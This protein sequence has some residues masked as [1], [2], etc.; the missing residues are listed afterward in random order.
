MSDIV[1]TAA[2]TSSVKGDIN[3]NVRIHAGYVREAVR[4]K[5]DFI[6]FPELSLTGYEPEL[7]SELAMSIDDPRLSP[8]RELAAKH[9][10]T[11]AAG[12]PIFRAREK[13]GIG[14]IVISPN[15]TSV[16]LKQHVTPDEKRHFSA[17]LVPCTVKVRGVSIGLAICADTSHASHAEIAAKL[18]ASVYA[19]GVLFDDAES[20][21]APRFQQYAARHHMAI[22]MANY[23]G[24][25]GGFVGVGKSGVWD[26]Q[27]RLIAAAPDGNALV[28]A[29]R[30]SGTW[31]GTA[32]PM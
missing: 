17:G 29:E 11:I 26:E 28:I 10:I 19:A 20:L 30:V 15:G 23:W 2:Q 14:A 9:E 5:A 7:A 1:I 21:W 13:P 31:K 18:G 3:A 12:T 4:H 24:P 22:L 16:Y 6:I 27:E 25:S 8:L 32:I